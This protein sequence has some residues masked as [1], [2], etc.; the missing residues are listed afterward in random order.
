MLGI[1]DSLATWLLAY[2]KRRDD[3]II[4]ELQNIMEIFVNKI[5]FE[6]V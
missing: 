1:K 3:R 6:I 4:S 2:F 5:K